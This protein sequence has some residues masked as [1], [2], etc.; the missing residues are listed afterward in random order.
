[1]S[2]TGP[3]ITEAKLARRDFTA[4]RVPAWPSSF[5]RWTKRLKDGTLLHVDFSHGR[6]RTMMEIPEDKVE[7]Q[8]AINVFADLMWLV[9]R[10]E[11]LIRYNGEEK[12]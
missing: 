3:Q 2:R 1:M 11:S 6:T 9:E 12:V 5:K 7:Y 4:S 10:I 8:L